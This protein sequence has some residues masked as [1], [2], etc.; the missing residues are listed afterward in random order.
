MKAIAATISPRWES[1]V[2]SAEI[3][4]GKSIRLYGVF[5]NLCAGPR[6]YDIT[7]QVGDRAEYASYNLPYVGTI[8]SIG[9]KTVTIEHGLHQKE[10]SRLDLE[11]FASRNWNFDEAKI[12]AEN[13]IE[14]QCI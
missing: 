4:P 10:R 5:K 7:F 9:A 11:H 14:M 8:V 13:L 2:Y 6:P 12:D 1:D 3:I